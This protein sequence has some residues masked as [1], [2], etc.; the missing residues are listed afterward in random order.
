MSHYRALA[1]IGEPLQGTGIGVNCHLTDSGLIRE[2][3]LCPVGTP[4][5][6]MPLPGLC[7]ALSGD[8]LLGSRMHYQVLCTLTVDATCPA[9]SAIYLPWLLQ[10][11]GHTVPLGL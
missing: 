8:S 10:Q 7:Q 9:A 2:M 1:D 3:A 6:G 5:A 11:D 4:T